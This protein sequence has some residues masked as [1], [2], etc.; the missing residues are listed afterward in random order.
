[1]PSRIAPR[2]ALLEFVPGA[3]RRSSSSTRAH[4]YV[5]I[6]DQGYWECLEYAVSNPRIFVDIGDDFLP[7]TGLPSTKQ[8]T[9]L[10]MMSSPCT[11]LE[12][13]I[14]TTDG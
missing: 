13:F 3:W 4:I 9:R 7:S 11:F 2:V 10:V 14:G 8:D 5:E 12:P 1:M 6:S